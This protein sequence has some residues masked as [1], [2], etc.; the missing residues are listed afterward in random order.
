MAQA[1]NNSAE[2]IIFGFLIVIALLSGC[3]LGQE[4]QN[5]EYKADRNLRGASG[6]NPSTLAMEFSLPFGF[7]PGRAGNSVPISLS[8]SSKVWNSKSLPTQSVEI[9]VNNGDILSQVTTVNQTLPM[10]S[11]RSISG[12]TSSLQVPAIIRGREF[13]NQHGE[14]HFLS[15]EI[16]DGTVS[17]VS[18][19]DPTAWR[20]ESEIRVSASCPSGY[21]IYTFC[22][23]A[24][25]QGSTSGYRI[26][27]T[28]HPAGNNGC[29][30]SGQPPCPGPTQY[31][32]MERRH[33]VPRI[34]V[35]MPDGS[36]KEFRLEDKSVDCL[37]APQDCE[38]Y[39]DGAYLSVDGSGMKLVVGDM[40]IGNA[41]HIVLYLGNGSRFV[42]PDTLNVQ[43]N[44][45]YLKATEYRDANGN[46]TGIDPLTGKWTDTLGREFGD[47]IP[48]VLN[49]QS[50]TVGERE[51]TLPGMSSPYK[52]TW[53]QLR[54]RLCVAG[55]EPE[56]AD[57]ILE[58]PGKELAYE[59]GDS[60]QSV[61]NNNPLSPALFSVNPI[62]TITNAPPYRY[63]EKDRIC[64]IMPPLRPD[65]GG[66][67]STP[68]KFNPVVMARV[69]LP[70]GQKY[71]FKYNEYGEITKILYP[72]GAVER[73]R[74]EHIPPIGATSDP[75]NRGVVERWLIADGLT[76]HWTYA[77]N[78]SG[79]EITTTAPDGSVTVRK[80]AYQATFGAFGFDN[81]TNGFPIEERVYRTDGLLASRKLTK[82]T[83]AP[84]RGT[85]PDPR[86]TRDPR[87]VGSI[88]ISF[89]DGK[90]LAVK[91]ET[92]YDENG[93]SDPSFFSHLNPKRTKSYQFVSVPLSTAQSETLT[94][95]Q[96]DALFANVPLASVSENDY[97]Y[98]ANYKDRGITSLLTESRVLNPLTFDPQS[99]TNEVLAKT[100]TIY[101]NTFPASNPNY[102]YSTETYGISGTFQCPSGSQTVTC[103]QSPNS[104]YLGR[105]TTVRL[106]DSDNNIWHESHTRYD[107]FGNA[108]KVKD[109]AGNEVETFF[110]NTAEKPYLYAYPTKVITPAPDP[111]GV[112]GT[113][114]GSQA[115]TTYDFTTGLPLSVTNDLG[116][117][118]K[119]EYNDPLLRPTRVYPFN[120][121]APESQTIYDDVNRTVKVRKQIDETHWDE[122]TT[123]MDTLGRAVKTQA[124][125][126]QGD[127]LVETEYDLLGRVKRTSNPYRQGDDIFWS[128]PRYDELSRVVETCAPSLNPGSGAAPCP[129]GTSTGTVSF[130]FSTVQNAIGTVVTSTDASGRRSRS[131]T[132]ALGQLIRVDEPT[133]IGGND[134][135]AIGAPNQPTYY[136]YNVQ[137][138][139]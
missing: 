77:A 114:Q 82:Y 78:S 101:D 91:S 119:T 112:Y 67:T 8:Y 59:G 45:F 105:P 48:N 87:P 13:F 66:P 44:S 129:T 10:F 128:R 123:F 70:N 2:S 124:T 58:D 49:Y 75:T 72:T 137:A 39:Q 1:K 83:V 96:L 108:V 14:I 139:W 55:T 122:A 92:E 64:S 99:T 11:R 104:A 19:S 52:L 127:V 126:S 113:N 136:T 12:W 103:W 135:G 34:R 107:I 120:F 97:A 3:A 88:L 26:D 50:Q 43:T 31:P 20:C 63:V 68:H 69:D 90:A 81:P 93:N 61:V 116:Q 33:V 74:Y 47:I 56:C 95:E 9:A 37:L 53:K 30:G 7:Y 21:E 60:C 25:D 134:L 42:F 102:P 98:D 71:E 27:C 130:S 15:G 138:S 16:A 5:S 132:N 131:I 84:P 73:F 24:D 100:E 4:R 109:P 121:T 89:E 46:K 117:T 62:E 80:M 54:N 133:A 40:T 57:T 115:T 41:R 76:Q 51:F 35:L 86:A 28:V 22:E 17:L 110:E 65:T 118:T 79:D 23:C 106:W 29:G 85:A 18:C 111:T 38:A 36:T 94:F 32:I 125:D 6:V